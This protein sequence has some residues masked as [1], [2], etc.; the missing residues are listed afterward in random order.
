MGPVYISGILS[1]I[2]TASFNNCLAAARPATSAKEMF[3]RSVKI[4][5]SIVCMNSEGGGRGAGR[6]AKGALAGPCGLIDGFGSG[7]IEGF[8]SGLIEG[9]GSGLID[10][11][12]SGLIEGFGAGFIGIF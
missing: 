2:I 11:F 3:G 6:G 7:L 10:G 8:G 9:F 12:G 4:A 1:G 5:V